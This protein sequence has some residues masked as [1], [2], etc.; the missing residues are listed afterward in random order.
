MDFRT[1]RALR[2]LNQDCPFAQ[3]QI[4]RSI[5]ETET[6]VGREPDNR[7]IW[8]SQL[9]ARGDAGSDDGVLQSWDAAIA[10]DWLPG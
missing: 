6:G 8:K 5:F 3:V 9:S 7:F 2:R 4:V 1:I 10:H